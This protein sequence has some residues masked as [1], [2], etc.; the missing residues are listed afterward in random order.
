MIHFVTDG[1]IKKL[2]YEL[3]NLIRF[4]RKIRDER[5]STNYSFKNFFES[6]LRMYS[7]LKVTVNHCDSEFNE[8]LNFDILITEI[9]I[10]NFTFKF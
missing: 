2:Y 8:C 9:K 4:L 7:Y 6:R 10:F 5:S 1:T 3:E